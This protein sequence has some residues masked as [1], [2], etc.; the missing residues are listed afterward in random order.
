MSTAQWANIDDDAGA[1]HALLRRVATHVEPGSIDYTWIF[2]ARKV[3]LGESIVIV[4][5]A[6]DED[7][8]RRR[9][10]TARFTIS[11]NRKGVADVKEKVDEH[12]AAPTDAVPRIVQGVLRRLGEDVDAEPRAE[13]I[14]GSADAWNALMV[15]LGGDP[16]PVPAADAVAAGDQSGSGEESPAEAE[17]AAAEAALHADAEAAVEPDP[18]QPGQEQPAAEKPGAEEA[19]ADAVIGSAAGIQPA[20]SPVPSSRDLSD[21]A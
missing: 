1:L 15:E 7:P 14:G 18:G 11:R 5:G 17:D 4:I 9:V 12:G 10:I 16:I 21:G 2:P 20:A 6:F 19:V 3:A 13:E 8:E